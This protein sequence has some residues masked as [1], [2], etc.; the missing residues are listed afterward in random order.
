M[1]FRNQ[2]WQLSFTNMHLESLFKTFINNLK[3]KKQYFKYYLFN[4]K[5]E[6][7]LTCFSKSH[8]KVEKQLRNGWCLQRDMIL[9]D[10]VER[11]EFSF[12]YMYEITIYQAS[13]LSRKLHYIRITFLKLYAFEEKKQLIYIYLSFLQTI[14][15]KVNMPIISNHIDLSCKL[16]NN[17]EVTFIFLS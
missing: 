11:Y 16:K 8:S 5:Q 14:V 2:K 3:N 9:L 12:Y 1:N 7:K 4:T 17:D 15:F 6:K 13:I 10:S